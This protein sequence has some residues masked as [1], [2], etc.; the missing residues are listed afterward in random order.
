[1]NKEVEVDTIIEKNLDKPCVCLC[2]N[3]KDRTRTLR[4]RIEDNSFLYTQS[5]LVEFAI[6]YNGSYADYGEHYI[7]DSEDGGQL[8]CRD[9]GEPIY[10]EE[11]D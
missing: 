6:E 2:S 7:G 10:I 8:V 9:C 11:V 1:M 5:I 4:K 3:K